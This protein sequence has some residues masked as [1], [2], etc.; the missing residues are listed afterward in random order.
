M[1]TNAVSA[2]DRMLAGQANAAVIAH[3]IITAARAG[4]E[5]FCNIPDGYR[6]CQLEHTTRN[7]ADLSEA[8]TRALIENPLGAIVNPTRCIWRRLSFFGRSSTETRWSVKML[9]HY[10]R[11]SAPIWWPPGVGKTHIMAAFG[12]RIKQQLDRELASMESKTVKL[13]DQIFA[14]TLYQQAD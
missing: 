11:R 7:L 4:L 12:L 10:D 13:I 14:T 1:N 2:L 3:E 9:T 6:H 5:Q 8:E